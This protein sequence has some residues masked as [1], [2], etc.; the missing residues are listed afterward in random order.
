VQA[1]FPSDGQSAKP[2]SSDTPSPTWPHLLI[3]P[4]QSHQLGTKHA[5]M[6]GMS[7]WGGVTSK[8]LQFLSSKG[9]SLT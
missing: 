7:G 5:S 3:L 2:T 9:V 4:K 1:G 8:L 6:P